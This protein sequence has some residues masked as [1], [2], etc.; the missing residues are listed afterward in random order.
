[1]AR[2]SPTKKLLRK[3]DGYV[4]GISYYGDHLLDQLNKKD[5][6]LT[7]IA[8]HLILQYDKKNPKKRKQF[9]K[10]T[11]KKILEIQRN[12]CAN[13]GKKLKIWDFDHI[14]D[15]R[16]NNDIS[17]CQALCPACHRLKTKRKI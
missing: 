8:S 3:L 13:C 1:M 17:N 12:R 16:T 2:K 15:D 11:K 5:R 4:P 6:A 14:D 10:L 7:E 9:S